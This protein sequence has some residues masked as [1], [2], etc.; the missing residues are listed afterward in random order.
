M[1]GTTE[2]AKTAASEGDFDR[3]FQMQLHGSDLLAF[4]DSANQDNT[5]L[6]FAVKTDNMSLLK[7]LKDLQTT[8]FD[9]KNANGETALHMCCGQ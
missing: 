7:F 8:D 6:H 2:L 1:K 5:L 4:K 3:L 9:A